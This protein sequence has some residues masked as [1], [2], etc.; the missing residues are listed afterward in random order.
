MCDCAVHCKDPGIQGMRGTKTSGMVS[1]PGHLSA[2]TSLPASK[3]VIQV[4]SAFVHCRVQNYRQH[5]IT[6]T[7]ALPHYHCLYTSIAAKS[8]L[9]RTLEIEPVTHKAPVLP[10]HETY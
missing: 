10:S 3:Q 9:V 5:R 1:N 2:G 7:A 6:L 4:Q 8:Y